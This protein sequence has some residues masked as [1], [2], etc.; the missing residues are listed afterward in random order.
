MPNNIK[1]IRENKGIKQSEL[2]EIL[3]ISQSALANKEA[4]RRLFT[5]EEVLKLE[6]LFDISIKDMFKEN[7]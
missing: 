1:N 3:N 2:A 4:G 7:K 5:V 6:E